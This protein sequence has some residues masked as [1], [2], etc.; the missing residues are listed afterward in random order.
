MCVLR[1]WSVVGEGVGSM[2]DGSGSAHRVLSSCFVRGV[3]GVSV[4]VGIADVCVGV[5]HGV[6]GVNDV[7]EGVGSIYDGSGSAQRLALLLCLGCGVRLRQKA[8]LL[9]FFGRK[10]APLLSLLL[11][12]FPNLG[13]CRHCYCSQ[14]LSHPPFPKLIFY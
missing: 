11:L 14:K 1:V 10:S 12:V 2:C 8:A 7:G 4:C 6:C 3:C 9:C 13:R 5:A